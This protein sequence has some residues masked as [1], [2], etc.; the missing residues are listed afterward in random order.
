M[1]QVLIFDLYY[2]YL[3]LR[4]V[5]LDPVMWSYPWCISLNATN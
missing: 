4:I 3:H 2:Q 5:N 1:W